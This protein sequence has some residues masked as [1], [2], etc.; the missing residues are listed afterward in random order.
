MT[1]ADEEN[2]ISENGN[3]ENNQK[4]NINKKKSN[5]EFER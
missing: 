5:R 3:E 1:D 2:Q 4:L